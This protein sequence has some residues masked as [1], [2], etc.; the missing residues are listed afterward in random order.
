MLAPPSLPLPVLPNVLVGY[1]TI[2]VFRMQMNIKWRHKG[3]RKVIFQDINKRSAV[4]ER[5]A[6]IE[7]LEQLD[8]VAESR[9]KVVSSRLGFAMRRLEN[10]LCRPSGE[11]VPFSN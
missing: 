4:V 3:R 6:V 1:I 11:W 2:T 10:S 9:P 8:Y 7:W 5:G